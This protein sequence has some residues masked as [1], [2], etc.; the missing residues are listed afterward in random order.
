MLYLARS[1]PAP[2]YPD[3]IPV[4][5]LCSP[6]HHRPNAHGRVAAESKQVL[7]SQ[8]IP[9]YETKKKAE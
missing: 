3:L 9:T 4:V 8:S 1:F 5:P 6:L 2:K 7:E